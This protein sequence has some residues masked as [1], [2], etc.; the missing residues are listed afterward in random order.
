MKHTTRS[1]HVHHLMKEHPHHHSSKQTPAE[2][3]I[4]GH[5]S[6]GARGRYAEG[7]QVDHPKEEEEREHHYEG[8]IS[9][10]APN[11]RKGGHTS[12]K[13]RSRRSQPRQHHYWGQEVIG[14]LPLVG[15]IANSIAHT[16][17]TLD[18]EK[19][20][21]SHYSA[22]SGGEKAAD[23]LS[24]LG[25]VGVPM[26]LK[27][28]GKAYHMHHLRHHKKMAAGGAGKVRKGMMTEEG[29]EITGYKYKGR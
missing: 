26:M 24:T 19:Y 10:A 7:G 4:R 8:G 11:F 17:G 2:I 5:S 29:H 27:K 22:K 14:R 1:A 25:N 23:I 9:N 15:H 21:G 16:V 6:N 28:G 12:E 3:L 13:H 20:G 18:P